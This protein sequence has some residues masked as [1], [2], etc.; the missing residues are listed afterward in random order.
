[1]ILC[2]R[3]NR[4]ASPSI[5]QAACMSFHCMSACLLLILKNLQHQTNAV[6][7]TIL[8]IFIACWDIRK[9][10]IYKMAMLTFS[11]CYTLI[12]VHWNSLFP[13]WNTALQTTIWW[14]DVIKSVYTNT[15]SEKMKYWTQSIKYY[16]PAKFCRSHT[17]NNITPLLHEAWESTRSPTSHENTTPVM[18]SVIVITLYSTILCQFK[19]TSVY[20]CINY[21]SSSHK[22]LWVNCRIYLICMRSFYLAKHVTC[23]S[24]TIQNY[25]S[26]LGSPLLPTFHK[27]CPSF[28]TLA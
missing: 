2:H 24:R 20:K 28:C 23:N 18:I 19:S 12:H 25:I 22:C 14:F 10:C 17:L 15:N 6:H 27:L 8:S 21:G 13:I 5:L 26:M 4:Y 11:F 1:M 3:L 9:L 7:K 16:V